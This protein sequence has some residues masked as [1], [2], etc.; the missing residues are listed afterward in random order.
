MWVLTDSFLTDLIVHSD[1]YSF[2]SQRMYQL[3]GVC[4][5][6]YDFLYRSPSKKHLPKVPV[7]VRITVGR[8]FSSSFFSVSPE[9]SVQKSRVKGFPYTSTLVRSEILAPQ[10]HWKW[11]RRIGNEKNGNFFG[12]K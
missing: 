8:R 9:T 10:N 1:F 6:F 2:H 12:K 4:H 5:R 7:N 3:A 11:E